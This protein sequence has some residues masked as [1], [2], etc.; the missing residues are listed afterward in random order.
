MQWCL[1]MQNLVIAVTVVGALAGC[2]TVLR[3][4]TAYVKPGLTTARL[5]A[6]EN[7]CRQQAVGQAETKTMPTWGQT[8]NRE[9]YDAC[10]RGLGYDVE[11]VA[12]SPRR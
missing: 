3:S 5:R 4:D 11:A 2:G 10:M 9:A 7:V 8:M 1:D 6:D 12:A